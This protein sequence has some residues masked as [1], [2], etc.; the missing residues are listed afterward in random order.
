MLE[1]VLSWGLEPSLMIGD[2]W[3]LS[4]SNLETMKNHRLGLLF[5]IESNRRV[6]VEKG[7][8]AQVQQLAITPDGRMVWLREF[9]EVKLFRTRLKDQLR[10]YVVF[11]PSTDDDPYSRFGPREFQKAHDQHWRIEQYHRLIKQVCHIERFQVS[12]KVPILNH[13]FTTLC[14]Y[15]QLQRM[16]FTDLISNAYQWQRNLHK[17]VV[18]SFVNSFLVGKEPLNP[19]FQPA[20][21]A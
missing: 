19:Q 6:S 7:Q 20:V 10:H 1:Q 8:W 13:I 12:G 9:G 14:S 21:N 11:L 18:V 5:A 2:G 17:D 15:V 3:Y 4:A 16:Q